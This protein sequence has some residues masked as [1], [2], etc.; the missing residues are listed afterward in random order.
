[1]GLC[2]PGRLARYTF[3]GHRPTPMTIAEA[4]RANQYRASLMRDADSPT[5]IP[6]EFYVP[7][8]A[9]SPPPSGRQLVASTSMA[10]AVPR[11]RQ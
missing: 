9:A 4:P 3:G 11:P 5:V 10:W 2:H 6:I 1:M 8:G 7:A